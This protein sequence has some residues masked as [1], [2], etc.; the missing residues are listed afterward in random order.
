MRGA[1]M[2]GGDWTRRWKQGSSFETCEAAS[3]TAWWMFEQSEH[4]PEPDYVV[5]RGRI[6]AGSRWHVALPRRGGSGSSKCRW[7]GSSHGRGI[8]GGR[9][10]GR[11]W[12][13]WPRTSGS[14]PGASWE[15]WGCSWRR[16]AC[17]RSWKFRAC[18]PGRKAPADTRVCIFSSG[19]CMLRKHCSSLPSA[20]SIGVSSLIYLSIISLRVNSYLR[21]KMELIRWLWFSSVCYVMRSDVNV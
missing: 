2:V 17:G 16:R 5:V 11:W 10:P 19:T 6:R 20:S 18:R 14:G 1:Y 15:C 3:L 21:I 7:A 4:T 13:S 8:P 12:R 9:W